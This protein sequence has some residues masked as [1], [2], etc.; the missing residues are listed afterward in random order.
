MR[1]KIFLN[2]Q[3]SEIIGITPRQVLSWTEK[4]LVIPFKES[5]GAGTKR[6]YDYTNLLEFGLC[7][8]LFFMGIGFRAIKKLTGHLRIHGSIEEWAKD[9][10]HYRIRSFER[11]KQSLRQLVKEDPEN[12][13][14]HLKLKEIEES[15]IDSYVPQKPTGVLVYFLGDEVED[16]FIITWDM[17]VVLNL[18]MIKQGFLESYG[19]IL[20]DLGRIKET[21]DR[22]L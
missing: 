16:V 7:K 12:R 22:R 18:S 10:P 11:S 2:R 14:W 19:G 6:G 13:T 5:T 21:I 17:D 8:V 1:N 20:I 15:S 9:F 4:G 3:V